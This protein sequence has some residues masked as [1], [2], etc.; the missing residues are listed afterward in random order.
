MAD[1]QSS[2]TPAG[3]AKAAQVAR[4][5][6][7]LSQAL[8]ANMARRKTQARARNSTAPDTDTTDSTDTVQHK[9]T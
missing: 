6:E 4:K 1:E 2:P 3:Q 7:R 5:Q 9:E 8:K